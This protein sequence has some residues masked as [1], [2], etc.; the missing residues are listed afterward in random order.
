MAAATFHIKQNGTTIAS[1]KAQGKQTRETI[2]QDNVVLSFKSPIPVTL[3]RHDHVEVYGQIYELNEPDDVIVSNTVDG[4]SYEATFEALYYRL[5]NFTLKTLDQN[6]LLRQ[7]MVYA[8]A[9]PWYIIDLIV[10]NANENDTDGGWEIGVI[11]SEEVQQHNF[12]SV[13]CLAALQDLANRYDTEFW[14]DGVN[15]KRINL[16]V[17]QASSGITLQYGQG[18]GL[19]NIKRTKSDKPYFNRLIIEG[20]SKNLPQD[21]GFASLQL[22]AANRPWLEH[23]SVINGVVERIVKYEN[24]FPSRIGTVTSIGGSLEIFDSSLDFDINEY[25]TPESAKISFISGQLAGFTFSIEAYDHASKK[26]SIN[27]ID[28]D[29]AYPIG[30]PNAYLKAAVGDQYVL[31]DIFLPESYVTAAQ[32][33]LLDIGTQLLNEGAT[34]QYNYDISITPKWVLENNFVPV[35]GNTVNIKNA[36]LGIDENIRIIGYTRDLQNSWDI[37]PKLANKAT[38]SDL[39]KNLYEQSKINDAVTSSGLNSATKVGSDTLDTVSK[40]GRFTSQI[41]EPRG[42]VVS[43]LFAPPMVEA[44]ASEMEPGR[45]YMRVRDAV[46]GGSPVH[47]IARLGDLLDVN[48][49]GDAEWV[50]YKK[51][52]G[53]F[54]FKAV[55]GGPGPDVYSKSEINAFFG[56][57]TPITGYN[58]GNWDATYGWGNHAAAGYAMANG[59]NASGNWAINANS[60]DNWNLYASGEAAGSAIIMTSMGGADRWH[61]RTLANFKSD[62]GLNISVT[63]VPD[64]IVRRGSSGIIDATYYYMSGPAVDAVGIADFVTTAGDG[65][66]RRSSI[67]TIKSYLGLPSSGGYDLQSVTDRGYNTSNP[68]TFGN[69]D[70]VL[71]YSYTTGQ[72]GFTI[73]RNQVGEFFIK[74]NGNVGFGTSSPMQKFVV[75][76]GGALGFEIYDD[77]PNNR[78]GLQVY[79]RATAQYGNLQLDG[80]N[81]S[82]NPNSG[83]L[84]LVGPSNYIDVRLCSNGGTT[85]GYLYADNQA[86]IGFLNTIHQWSMRVEENGYVTATSFVTQ[87]DWFR[88]T[89]AGGIFFST[90]GGGL[91]MEDAVYVR[92]S[93][94]K[95]FYAE[96]ALFNQKMTAKHIEATAALR[97]P[98]VEL[99]A[100]DMVPGEY[101]LR[102]REL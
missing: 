20:G 59:S 72:E 19:Y 15:G 56:G 82:I 83:M 81:I 38:V 95:T 62:L 49:D 80:S 60:A 77:S 91:Y 57:S 58:K 34:D 99:D 47:V 43:D 28:D 78:F 84:S 2:A 73:Y 48:T 23:S 42:V 14:F 97:V 17:R 68:I 86:N 64:T 10:K 36:A 102:I 16:S 29:P 12:A 8:M 101:Y 75:S 13:T 71:K 45:Y 30:V 53:T 24:I 6:N 44:S 37:Q 67:G 79:N 54:G 74:N 3:Q 63:A 11:D 41:I 46:A 88:T 1:A 33:K 66:L 39:F 76:N 94:G 50:L 9:K 100:A 7:T 35:L 92:V 18:K 22:P 27:L 21:Y 31:L 51:L 5:G 26:I 32:N 52:D 87:N 40:R 65:Y 61:Y 93:H 90:F 25:L 98:K 85:R 4:Y 69:S 89:G 70:F 55:A 96:N